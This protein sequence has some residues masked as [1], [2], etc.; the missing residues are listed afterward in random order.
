MINRFTISLLLLIVGACVEESTP[1]EAEK[2]AAAIEQDEVKARQLSIEVAA[3]RATKLIEEDAKAE[4]DAATS[5][6]DN[7]N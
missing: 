3:E 6:A 5:N 4:I 2:A 7:L 1:K